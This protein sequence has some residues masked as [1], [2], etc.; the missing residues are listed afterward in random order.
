MIEAKIAL[1][2]ILIAL[3]LLSVY[4]TALPGL[5]RID[6]PGRGPGASLVQKSHLFPLI[7]DI[8]GRA[9]SGAIDGAPA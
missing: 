9:G 4:I 7:G 3:L 2:V 1:M 8:R 5:T 6:V